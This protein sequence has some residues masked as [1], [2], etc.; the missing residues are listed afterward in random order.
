VASSQPI[1]SQAGL[2]VLRIGGNAVDAA[3][4]VA[5]ALQVT[6]PTSTGLGGDCFLL[7]YDARLKKVSAL[8]GSGRSPKAF[9][10]DIAKSVS[11]IG[12][13]RM[14]ADSVHCVTVPGAAAGWCDAIEKWGSMKLVDV[15]APAVKLAE[16]GWPVAEITALQWMM[17][18]D[19]LRPEGLRNALLTKDRGTG[20]FRAPKAGEI[21]RNP[22]LANVLRE[23]GAGGKEAFY[24]G[25]IAEAIV[26]V[27][28]TMGSSMTKEDLEEHRSTFPEPISVKYRDMEIVEVPPNGQGVAAL[29]ALNILEDAN[30]AGEGINPNR[31]IPGS[32]EHLHLLIEAMRLSFADAKHFVADPDVVDVPV[33]AML[34]PAYAKE[35]RK[36]IDPTKATADIKRGIPAAGS[37][38]VSFQVVDKD[39]NAVS[40]VNSN[41]EGF[42]SGIVPKDCGFSLQNRGANFSVDPENMNVAAAKKRP[43]HTII[44]AL[45]LHHDTKELFATFTN[46]GG[47]AQAPAH[48][49]LV[50]NLLDFQMN[51]QIAIDRP[52]FIIMNGDANGA[53]ALEEGIATNVAQ[54]LEDMGHEILKDPHGMMIVMGHARSIFGRAQIVVRDRKSGVLI[55]GSDGRCDGQAVGF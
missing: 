25:R 53:V 36:L 16:D 23:L 1:A 15:L 9:S 46:M 41:Y 11:E 30:N 49:Q 32:K 39:G 38:T 22:D 12:K 35:R 40:M 10:L 31:H 21:F 17:Q 20:T 48:V 43:Y 6:E 55:A 27:L 7:F 47:F 5:A 44:P 54:E 29:M 4:A 52:R 42:G 37:D 24:H 8:N 13:D 3:I 14:K 28:K 45:A 2:E 26:D 34:N 51:P 50:V 33:K 18:E 19:Q